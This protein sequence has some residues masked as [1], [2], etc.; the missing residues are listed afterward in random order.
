M[1]EEK[2]SKIR[3]SRKYLE[4][5][6]EKKIQREREKERMQERSEIGMEKVRKR[7]RE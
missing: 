5:E 3:G 4:M 7:Q 2:L 6:G 1:R